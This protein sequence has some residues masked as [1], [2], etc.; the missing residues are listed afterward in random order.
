MSGNEN[1]NECRCHLIIIQRLAPAISTYASFSF[2]PSSTKHY[3]YSINHFY[4]PSPQSL[5]PFKLYTPLY[6]I[7]LHSALYTTLLH[8]HFHTSTMSTLSTTST[9]S[10]SSEEHP[11]DTSSPNHGPS[12]DSNNPP[13][14]QTG[15]CYC[16]DWNPTTHA[17]PQQMPSAV[18]TLTNISA[19]ALPRSVEEDSQLHRTVRDERTPSSPTHSPSGLPSSDQPIPLTTPMPPVDDVPSIETTPPTSGQGRDFSSKKVT[20]PGSAAPA[21]APMHLGCGFASGPRTQGGYGYGGSG[22]GGIPLFNPPGELYV[23]IDVNGGFFHMGIRSYPDPIRESLRAA[24][25]RYVEFG[26]GVCTVC[27]LE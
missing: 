12:V 7:F 2:F 17:P 24:G 27:P 15:R 3:F 4:Y 18:N 6:S 14:L 22:Q 23:D 19:M 5:N 21:L 26:P 20:E 10:A 13:C 9:I 11:Q 8:L 25:L 1:S 16:P